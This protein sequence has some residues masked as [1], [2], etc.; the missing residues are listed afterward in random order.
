MAAYQ[1]PNARQRS[2]TANVVAGLGSQVIYNTGGQ[3]AFGAG[4]R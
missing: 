2:R 1:S 4:P 3:N